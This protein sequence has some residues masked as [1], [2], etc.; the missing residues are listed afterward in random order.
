[1]S[2]F[3]R[4]LKFG[5]SPLLMKPAP[6]P[7][8][9]T[10]GPQPKQ[11]AVFITR[12]WKQTSVKTWQVKRQLSLALRYRGSLLFLLNFRAVCSLGDIIAMCLMSCATF[13]SI[14]TDKRKEI[15]SLFCMALIYS[16]GTIKQE[17][18]NTDIQ[19]VP[20]L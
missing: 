16:P 20:H 18:C 12:E 19:C 7:R 13:F 1:M 6:R 4:D 8:H 3:I 10:P 11:K 14:T 9:T 17:Y 15:T 5:Y 2:Q